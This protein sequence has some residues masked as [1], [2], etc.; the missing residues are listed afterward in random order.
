MYYSY[1]EIKYVARSF[2][3]ARTDLA[4]KLLSGSKAVI[5]LENN[6]YADTH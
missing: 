2:A 1:V 3:P 4:V 6:R 5:S